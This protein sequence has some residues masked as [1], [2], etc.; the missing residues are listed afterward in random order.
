MNTS[1]QIIIY[2]CLSG[3]RQCSWMSSSLSTTCIRRSSCKEQQQHLQECIK[4]DK[5]KKQNKEQL[6]KDII[7]KSQLQFC[8]YLSL[9]L[10]NTT[11]SE[12]QGLFV[13]PTKEGQ[14]SEELNGI[15]Y[16]YLKAVSCDLWKLTLCIILFI[17]FISF[18]LYSVLHT[19]LSDVL[20]ER[21]VYVRVLCGIQRFGLSTKVL[22]DGQ[23]P[24]AR[25]PLRRSPVSVGRPVVGCTTDGG[26]TVPRDHNKGLL[27]SPWL[28]LQWK[29]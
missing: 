26:P 16:V 9:V 12:F 28:D 18:I 1:I 5:W 19:T 6:E 29:Y 23:R 24:T 25:V 4:A 20:R 7:M 15:I 14:R 13:Q 3:C 11:G 22:T 27:E 8:S 10:T 21:D 17:H 2:A